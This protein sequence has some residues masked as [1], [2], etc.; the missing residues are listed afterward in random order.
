MPYL[1]LGR[2]RGFVLSR[3]A[4]IKLVFLCAELAWLGSELTVY[5]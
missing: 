4:E 1:I 2:F 3:G 5:S